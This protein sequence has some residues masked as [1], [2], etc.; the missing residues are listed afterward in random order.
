MDAVQRYT[1][2]VIIGARPEEIFEFYTDL[3]QLLRM[4]SPSLL[5]KVLR[6][7][8]PLRLGARVEFEVGPKNLPLSVKWTSEITEFKYPFA[9]EDRQVSGPFS[10]WVHRHEFQPLPDGTTA[11][12]DIIEV[13][14]A[15]G[16]L[17]Q[18][19]NSVLLGKNIAELFTYRKRVLEEKF[20]PIRA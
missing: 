3:D 5:V 12:T 7:D 6:A 19:I 20:G 4:L 16:I 11:V 14:S 13:G 18:A 2:T 17:G 9:F 10:R 1:D 15:K 8:S